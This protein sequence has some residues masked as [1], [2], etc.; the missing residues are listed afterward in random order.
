MS[1]CK[2]KQLSTKTI[3]SLILFCHRHFS[4]QTDLTQQQQNTKADLSK[5]F[6]SFLTKCTTK[7]QHTDNQKFPWKC[8]KVQIIQTVH[9]TAKLELLASFQGTVW[10]HRKYGLSA[11]GYIASSGGPVTHANKAFK[12]ASSRRKLLH[13]F[14][15]TNCCNTARAYS[16]TT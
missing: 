12:S 15:N 11:F 5:H 3:R 1:S 4:S 13:V 16:E 14:A 7:S 9:L 10:H 6:E 8:G 2:T